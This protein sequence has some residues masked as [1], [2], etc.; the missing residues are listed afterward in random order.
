[1]SIHQ[2]ANVKSVR[3]VVHVDR[4]GKVE[5]VLVVETTLQTNTQDPNF[6]VGGEFDDL[7]DEIVEEMKSNCSLDRA[8]IMN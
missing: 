1:M 2:N 3:H 6:N 4:A 5:R 7:V 8:E